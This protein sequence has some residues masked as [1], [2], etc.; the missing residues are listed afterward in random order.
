MLYLRGADDMAIYNELTRRNLWREHLRPQGRM[1]SSWPGFIYGAMGM[2]A[3]ND[4]PAMHIPVGPPFSVDMA[5]EH[6][7]LW[8]MLRPT[9]FMMTSS[10]L[11]LYDQAAAEM[12]VTMAEIF[13]GGHVAFL[14][15][16]CQ[17]D[18]PREQLEKQYNMHIYNISGAS[19]MVGA[20]VTDCR[21]HTG[22]HTAAEYVIAQICDPKTGREVPE[23]G[24][25]HLVWTAIGG[26]SVWMRYNVEDWAEHMPGDC[27]CGE[28][29][30][31]YRLLGREGDR[32]EINGKQI[33]PLDVQLAVNDHGAPELMVEKGK[34]PGVLCVKV[35]TGG[36]GA[37]LAAV[38]QR[39]LSVPVEVTPVP[40]ASLP[41]STFKPKRA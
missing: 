38:I 40:V 11:Y 12:G 17:Y 14:E 33:F 37:D 26:N 19:E 22:F 6:I 13:N 21:Y 18:G 15:A 27:P 39:A 4:F 20:M 9:N 35:E 8:Q 25:G 3:L 16:I 10:Q 36:D 31:R 28:T 5:K 24:R 34:K 29:G 2:S 23:G 32:Q 41:R 7:A 1:T 30:M